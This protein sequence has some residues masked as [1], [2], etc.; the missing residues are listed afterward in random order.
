[1]PGAQV[2]ISRDPAER[3]LFVAFSVLHLCVSQQGPV[4]ANV[5]PGLVAVAAAVPAATHLESQVRA[6]FQPRHIH[7]GS[8]Q[9]QQPSHIPRPWCAKSVHHRWWLWWAVH[10]YSAGVIVLAQGQ[11]AAGVVTFL[12]LPN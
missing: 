4:E 9:Q 12:Y 11:E 10:C 2:S 5:E 8:L 3:L 7:N 1:M 6:A